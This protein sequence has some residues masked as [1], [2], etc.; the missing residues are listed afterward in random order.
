M[1]GCALRA[2]QRVCETL[3]EKRLYR[4]FKSGL[5]R[6]QP[7]FHAIA[8]PPRPPRLLAQRRSPS[9]W[10]VQRGALAAIRPRT[11][12]RLALPCAPADGKRQ[13]IKIADRPLAPRQRTTFVPLERRLRGPQHSRE[14]RR[15]GAVAVP[16]QPKQILDRKRRRTSIFFGYVKVDG[17]ERQSC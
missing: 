14:R 16:Q 12:A 4:T 6:N 7:G 3:R 1:R 8:A 5:F 15:D 2:V 17:R 11:V 10:R 13:R 9:H